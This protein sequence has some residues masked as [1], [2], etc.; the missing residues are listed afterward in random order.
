MWLQTG[1]L[2]YYYLIIYPRN[3]LTVL[4]NLIIRYTPVKSKIVHAKASSNKEE[5]R[6]RK[7]TRYGDD[8]LARPYLPRKRRSLNNDLVDV[9]ECKQ[10]TYC[11]DER[12][13][14]VTVGGDMAY[15][16]GRED[17]LRI[18]KSQ[19]S[20]KMDDDDRINYHI[21]D[22][23][24]RNVLNSRRSSSG[25]STT[26]SLR[27]EL[28]IGAFIDSSR[29]KRASFLFFTCPPEQFMAFEGSCVATS[30][31]LHENMI[32]IVTDATV[33]SIKVDEISG[34]YP[35]SHRDPIET[36]RDIQTIVLT[37]MNPIKVCAE[38]YRATDVIFIVF[39]FS[40]CIDL[41]GN[42]SKM[43]KKR[44]DSIC[45]TMRWAG[46][47]WEVYDD[48]RLFAG[49]NKYQ[50]T[51]ML[52]DNCQPVKNIFDLLSRLNPPNMYSIN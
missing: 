34:H 26:S 13:T 11:K 52:P 48:I 9:G 22:S 17:D 7:A 3:N 43:Q 30:V 4:P 10:I 45:K 42:M 50:S 16:C 29:E 40:V 51:S 24:L 15:S 36:I 38:I 37:P 25:S 49:R 32:S 5:T 21:D 8:F 14:P 28:L 12:N 47:D 41:I 1:M 33:A 18:Q 23:R 46:E 35:L 6:S 39:V 31:V 20:F 2:L 44:L 19:T 27:C